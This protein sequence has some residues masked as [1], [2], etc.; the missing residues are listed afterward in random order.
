MTAK[1][2]VIEPDNLLSPL[3]TAHCFW[4]PRCRY[5]VIDTPNAAHDAMEQH[6]RKLHHEDIRRI[7]GWCS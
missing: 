7:V 1:G 5:E 4:H 6:Y 2:L 3:V